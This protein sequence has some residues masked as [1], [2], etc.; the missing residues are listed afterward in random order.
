VRGFLD[1]QRLEKAESHLNEWNYLP[2]N[3]WNPM[4]SGQ[5]E[6]R[7]RWYARQGGAEG[8]AFAACALMELQDAPLDVANYFSADSQP[9]GLFTF[10]GVPK[11]TFYAFKAFQM[12]HDTPTRVEAIG[13]EPGSS[14]VLAGIGSDEAMILVSNFRS[15]SDEFRLPLAGLPWSGNTVAETMILDAN[16]NLESVRTNLFP[17]GPFSLMIEL[18]A[19]AVA[20]LRLRT[21]SVK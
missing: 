13:G 16:R 19:P 6:T 7:E 20:L 18:K 5:G 2:D 9:F 8:A 1:A 10:H 21:R 11:K 12:L 14:A 3:D 17:A 15:D 4:T